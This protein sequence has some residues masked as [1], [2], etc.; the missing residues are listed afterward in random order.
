MSKLGSLGGMPWRG[1]GEHRINDATCRQELWQWEEVPS[2]GARKG[3]RNT[4]RGQ[5]QRCLSRD[6]RNEFRHENATAKSDCEAVLGLSGQRSIWSSTVG[7]QTSSVFL[8]GVWLLSGHNHNLITS[9]W[10]ASREQCLL[11]A[12][13]QPVPCGWAYLLIYLKLQRPKMPGGVCSYRAGQKLLSV[14]KSN[15]HVAWGL[16]IRQ[17]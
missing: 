11:Q 9:M 17:S 10:A 16:D 8:Y 15:S 14:K 12:F 6:C 4:G 2:L 5:G 13:V 3:W 7:L 1:A